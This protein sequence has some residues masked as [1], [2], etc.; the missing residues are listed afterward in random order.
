[1]TLRCGAVAIGRPVAHA[2]EFN[3]VFDVTFNFTL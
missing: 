3:D 1:M 2:P